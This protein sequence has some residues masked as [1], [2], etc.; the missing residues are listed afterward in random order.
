MFI[1][2]SIIEEVV[3]VITPNNHPINLSYSPSS[4]KY[5]YLTASSGSN[6]Y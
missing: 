1:G 2:M 5:V 4:Y 3:K 6:S